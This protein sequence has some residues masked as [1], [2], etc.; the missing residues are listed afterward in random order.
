LLY[1]TAGVPPPAGYVFVGSFEQSLRPN[2]ALPNGR[3]ETNGGAE[4]KL[5]V[6]VYRKQ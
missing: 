1:L 5:F 2:V 6:N 4:V 3:T